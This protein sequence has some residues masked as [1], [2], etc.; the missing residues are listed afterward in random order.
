WPDRKRFGDD[1]AAAAFLILQHAISR[2]DLQRSGLAL[3]VA[4]VERGEANALDVAYLADRIA[5]YEGRPQLFG[6]QFDWD[7]D[8]LLSPAP[9]ADP[10]GVEARRAEI[11]LPP[12]AS[13]I[14]RM[15]IGAAA[16]GEG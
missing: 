14:E 11:G 1:G 4:G 7:A 9:L 15:R 5:V 16:E 13:T 6:T 12:L 8:G 2:P 3:L 10:E